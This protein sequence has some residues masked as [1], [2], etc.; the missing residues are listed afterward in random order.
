MSVSNDHGT[1]RSLSPWARGIASR[2]ESFSPDEKLV[3]E[4]IVQGI[5]KGREVYG[6]MFLDR[7]GRDLVAEADDEA[8]DWLIYRAMRRMQK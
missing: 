2:M 7:D 4:R 3:I 8:R 5:E 1:T 6:P